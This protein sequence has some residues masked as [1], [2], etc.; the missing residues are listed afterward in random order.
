[1]REHVDDFISQYTAR[2]EQGDT[3]G[4]PTGFSNIDTTTYGV[5]PG[6][7]WVLV[8][9]PMSYKTWLMCRMFLTSCQTVEGSVLFFSKEMTK[10]QIQ[11]RVYAIAG[12]VSFSDLRR[13]KL[14][15]VDLAKIS[16]TMASIKATPVII[17]RDVKDPYDVSYIRSKIVEYD[18]KIAFVDGLYLLGKSADWKDQTD[19]TR[20]IRDVALATNTGIVGTTQ[21][22][23]KGSNAATLDNLAYSDSFA[24]DASVVISLER[25]RDSITEK[26]TKAVRLTTIKVRDDEADHT[27]HIRVGFKRSQFAEGQGPDLDEEDT[28]QEEAFNDGTKTGV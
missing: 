6:D 7:F 24:Q 19:S 21:Y 25:E 9:R 26:M 13:Y 17:G 18:A 22:N 2:R 20:S 28:W 27:M 11:R 5:H 3:H 10:E 15:D 12:G 14:N 4:I 16:A 8:A 23:R 1:L